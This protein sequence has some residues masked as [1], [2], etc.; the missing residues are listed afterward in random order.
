M[1]A[2]NF[3]S[4]FFI[5][6]MIEYKKILFYILKGET[7]NMSSKIKKLPLATSE[8]MLGFGVGGLLLN[9][10]SQVL[11]K[12]FGFITLILFLN[13]FSKLLL[14][15]K[16]VK[17]DL[18][19]PLIASIFPSFFMGGMILTTYLQKYIG[20]GAL[21]LW[22][23]LVLSHFLFIYTY[24]KKFLWSFKL[25]MIYPSIFITYSG[26]FMVSITAKYF[27]M[28]YIGQLAFWF[29][30]FSF[31]LFLPFVL[32]RVFKYKDLTE[33]EIPTLG[34]LCAPGAMGVIGYL[35]V[36]HDINMYMVVFLLTISTFIYFMV[37]GIIGK[38]IKVPFNYNFSSFTFPMLICPLGSK[39]AYEYLSKLSDFSNFGMLIKGQ[40]IIGFIIL[41]YISVR[42][43][44]SIYLKD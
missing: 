4:C 25:K 20:G 26:L 2:Y 40:E 37:L 30:L 10:Y 24:T 7:N 17:K 28:F 16:G 19:N 35:T 34:N 22:E 11:S 18:N 36:F 44:I 13:I 8:L 38:L 1:A 9:S 23:V 41:I 33:K 6:S 21:I 39:V 14:D 31:I 42:Y 5:E 27:D 43:F 29:G 32:F 15:N 12:A 3:V